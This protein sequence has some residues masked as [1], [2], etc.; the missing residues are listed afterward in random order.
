MARPDILV[1]AGPTAAGKTA[2]SIAMAKR[3]GG[4]VVS[5]DSMQLYKYM[6][7]G[8]AKPTAEEMDG[9][10]HHM[11]GV[12]DPREPFSVAV[13]QEM[14]KA[15][16]ADIASRGKLPVICGGTGLYLNAL[17][18]EMDF[19]PSRR[20][21]TYRREL[22]AFADKEGNEALHA[23]LESVDPA[24]AAR[25]HPNNR[26]RVIRALEA[27]ELDGKPLDAFE[28]VRRKSDSYHARMLG[29]TW[30]RPTLYQRI[31]DRVDQMLADGLVEEVRGLM[32]MGF[33][34][35]DIA[36]KGIGYKELLDCFAGLYPMEEAVRL[37]KRNT[38]HYAKRQL[39][40]FKRY[41]E[42]VWFNGSDYPDKESWLEDM[43][44]WADRR[45]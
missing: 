5:C 25:I 18:Y 40:W 7:I 12:I 17:L 4:E 21:D 16:I 45:S 23:R 27:A 2:V 15:V 26:K 1:V 8:S 37:I 19:G 29:I 31:D 36:M 14:A 30:D 9:V 38:R 32:D 20:D 6:D 13:Y 43:Y 39:T 42:M 28:S 35:D 33:T 24:A 34:S 41:E 22:E 10:P 44:E 11:V 3:Y